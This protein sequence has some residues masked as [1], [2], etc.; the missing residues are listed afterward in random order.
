M[1]RQIAMLA[2]VYCQ[3]GLLMVGKGVA[4][5]WINDGPGNLVEALC[6]WSRAV[7]Y[8]PAALGGV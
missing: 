8:G 7:R 6:V 1:A 2:D 3:S 4:I 5:V